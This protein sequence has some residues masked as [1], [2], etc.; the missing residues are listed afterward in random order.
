MLLKQF[1]LYMLKSYLRLGLFFYFK[2][3]VVSGVKNI[4]KDKPVLLLSNH[5]NALLDALLIAT[6]IKDYGHYLARAGVFKKALVSKLLQ[7]LQLIPVYRI[8]DGYSNLTNNNEI[9]E[10]AAN[11][12]NENK[13]VTIFPEG[14]HNLARRLRP[15]SKGFTR[16]V[17][18]VLDKNPESELLLIP[19]GVNFTN[20]KACPDSAAIYFG[21]PIVAK[22]YLKDD[23]HKAV[24]N[25]KNDVHKAISQLTTHIPEENY[26]EVLAKL[27]SLNVD[28]L[29]P[30]SVNNCIT[31]NFETC[32]SKPKSKGNWLRVGLKYLLILN[33]LLP[34]AIWK[35]VAQPKIN[36]IE[37]ASTFRFAIAVTLVP[38][39]LLI[40]GMMLT[41][42]FSF[43][44][45]LAYLVGVLVLALM[46]IKS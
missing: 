17:F 43:K 16:I 24:V 33:L 18:N 42:I 39:Y 36:E 38:I 40:A 28:F 14:S 9:F 4:P 31:S 11:L 35:L 23:K 13:T 27:E 20:A 2:R 46:A 1:R 22:Q 5:Q 32:K 6:S 26:D 10:T 37:F 19:I 30:Q 41:I 15:L 3:V 8:R 21:K 34:Y 44:V 45:A 29:N 25:L 12:L 7:S